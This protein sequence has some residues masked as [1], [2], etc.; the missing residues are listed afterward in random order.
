MRGDGLRRRA[1]EPGEPPVGEGDPFR[2][3]GADRGERFEIVAVAAGHASNGVDARPV[4]L[5]EH[6]GAGLAGGAGVEGRPIA[7]ADHQVI[8][9]EHDLADVCLEAGCRGRG[10]DRLSGRLRH[11]G[12]R[13]RFEVLSER[14]DERT[15]G[16]DGGDGDLLEH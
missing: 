16:L 7:H 1:V 10:L 15:G 11:V 3:R 13:L 14:A 9:R 4:K 5:L 12:R 8:V 2:H 6:R